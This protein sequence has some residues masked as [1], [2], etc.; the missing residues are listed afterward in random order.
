MAKSWLVR[1]LVPG[2]VHVQGSRLLAMAHH[3]A[4][5]LHTR[6]HDTCMDDHRR[7]AGCDPRTSPTSRLGRAASIIVF[8]FFLSCLAR[9]VTL[10]DFP[11]TSL[12]CLLSSASCPTCIIIPPSRDQINNYAP[13]ESCPAWE[14]SLYFTHY[15]M[16]LRTQNK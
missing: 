8:S 1:A 15:S 10:P 2:H 6:L 7:S 4:Y 9:M 13:Y 12:R 3:L 14:K 5:S 11:R 16:G